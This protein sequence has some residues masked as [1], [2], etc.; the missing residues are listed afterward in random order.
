MSMRRDVSTKALIP[1][2]QYLRE[3]EGVSPEKLYEGLA[4]T[5]EEA[6]DPSR[7]ISWDLFAAIMKR[8]SELIAPGRDLLSVGHYGPKG[9]A[10]GDREP[11]KKALKTLGSFFASSKVLYRLVVKVLVPMYFPA[12][13]VEYEELGPLKIRLTFEIPAEYKSCPEFFQVWT[14]NLVATPAVLGQPDALVQSDIASHRAVYTVTIPPSQTILTRLSRAWRV[15]FFARG[16]YKIIEIQQEQVKSHYEELLQLQKSLLENE[17]KL[18]LSSQMA[19]L[20]KMSA[21]GEMAGGVAHEV[22]NPLATILMAAE[23]MLLQLQSPDLI[24]REKMESQLNVISRMVKRTAAIVDSLRS[25]SGATREQ[26]FE[27]AGLNQILENVL[28]L[29]RE[30]LK[31]LGVEVRQAGF[32]QQFRI[33]CRMAEISQVIFNLLSNSRDFIEKNAEKWIE[34]RLNMDATGNFVELSVTDSGF[35]IP[36]DIRDKIFQP[37]FTTRA[38]GQGT[39]LGLAAAKGIIEAHRGT[40][41]LDPAARNTRFVV[42]LPLWNDV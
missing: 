39:G 11:L 29:N 8:N 4:F 22:N 6:Q 1:I 18:K 9:S 31:N 17:I 5:Y 13:R 21:L 40:I 34:L 27:S 32:D 23:S 24:N 28:T 12:V 37:F 3:V 2:Q 26:P 19:H 30:K 33:E 42:S 41:R 10:K 38:P 20:S 36:A 15:L 16:F 25:F 7:F 35:G 14:G